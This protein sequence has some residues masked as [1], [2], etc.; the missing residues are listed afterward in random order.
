[1]KEQ[2]QLVGNCWASNDNN[3]RN[4]N[5][6]DKHNEYSL[7]SARG[8][9]DSQNENS[10]IYDDGNSGMSNNNDNRT[11]YTSLMICFNSIAKSHC[12]ER[13]LCYF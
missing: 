11:D 13:M 7:A 10:A 9:L 5:T 2:L 4:N 8:G 6:R 3:N 12:S 1:M